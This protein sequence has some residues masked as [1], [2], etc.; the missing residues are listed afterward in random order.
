MPSSLSITETSLPDGKI[1]Y[2]MGVDNW[3]TR[4]IPDIRRP[5]GTAQVAESRMI[6]VVV[7]GDGFTDAADFRD[8]LEEWLAAFYAIQV[9]DVFSGCLRVRGLYTRST[10]PASPRRD[11]YYRTMVTPE[12]PL[13][14][15]IEWWS[16]ADLDGAAFR[17][18][19]WESVD[20]MPDVVLRRYPAD[21]D[22]GSDDQPITNGQ[23]RDLYRNLVVC[24]L[25]KTAATR[26]PSGFVREVARPEP[27][28]T[29]RVTVAFGAS[30]MHELGHA[31]GLLGDEYVDKR[32]VATGRV[33]PEVRS[34][35]SLS[36]LGFSDLADEVAWNHLSSDGWRSRD[37]G[38][39]GS[40]VGRLWVGGNSH[41]RVWH[42][43]YRCLMNGRHNNFAFTQIAAED[44]TA[45]GDGSYS[46]TGEDLRDDD[47]FCLWC[48]EV[49]TLRILE[50]TDQ[51][52][53]DGDPE[54]ET[55]RGILWYSR[56]VQDLRENYYALFDVAGQI[57]ALEARYAGMAPGA[58]GE[59]LRR[60]DLYSVPGTE[61][62]SPWPSIGGF[63][64]AAAPIAVT[65]RSDDN[66]DLFI[67]GND[68]TVRTSWWRDGEG[69]SGAEDDWSS[70]AGMFAA[71]TPIAAV[72][73]AREN[74][75]VFAVGRDGR[76]RTAWWRAGEDWAGN[77]VDVNGDGKADGDWMAIGG[78]FS[79]S[80]PV[81]AVSRARENIDVFAIGDDG[82]V[83]TAW[84][85]AGGGW[86]STDWEAIGG[87]FPPGAP[88]AA[89]SRARENIDVFAVGDDGR[90]YTAWWRA[91][92][93]WSSTDGSWHPIGGSFAP[94]T[95]IAAV[96]RSRE[97]IDLY[98]VDADGRVRTA[99]WR[100]G[101]GWAPGDGS[102][103][104]IGG[105][106]RAAAPVTA[107][108]RSRE[109]IDV[110]I[111]GEDGLVYTSWWRAGEGW[112]AAEADWWHPIRGNFPPGVPVAAI[113]RSRGDIDLYA[114]QGDGRVATSWWRDGEGWA[115]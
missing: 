114:T 28:A 110:F 66:I 49:V 14:P 81:A 80:T 61:C 9:Y 77:D 10:E 36:N 94:R 33:E 89:V 69:W 79:P 71:G 93:G 58:G 50:K 84:W 31:L 63:F 47:R 53:E 88:L 18:K 34:V 22:V 83:Y 6:D 39:P 67:A 74:I 24:M 45:N 48:Q 64:P 99:W 8:A 54:D 105:Y 70:L 60:S 2:D 100:A 86:S 92:E 29:H 115:A 35:F 103:S 46:G 30:E 68:G 23:L 108:A 11:S 20:S 26:H 5:G 1:R 59:P 38:R 113:S 109:N 72:S 56:W 44:P 3:E 106:F 78:S 37:A 62:P 41:R 13:E 19:L 112:S 91:G 27:S 97:N 65:A 25:V 104:P 107:V 82:R 73:R 85:R 55:R 98:A 32:E 87:S 4:R 95:P 40:L 12:G 101:V 102:F 16:A 57:D 76:V 111:T 15:E 42:S 7:L 52:L 90:V 17:V 96:T 75:D 21:L 51:L 43:E